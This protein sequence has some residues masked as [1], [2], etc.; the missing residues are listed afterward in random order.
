[1]AAHP[2]PL[3]GVAAGDPDRG[4]LQRQ[5]LGGGRRLVAAGLVRA[6][7]G[8]VSVRLGVGLLITATGARLGALTDSDVVAVPRLG[9]L[10]ARASSEVATHT[11]IL[12]ARPDVGAV[13]HTHSPYAT[14]W[15]CLGEPLE[16]ALEEAGYYRMGSIV[17]L[18]GHAPGGSPALASGAAA[19]LGDGAAVLLERHGAIAVGRDLDVAIDIAESLEHQAQVAWLL[20]GGVALR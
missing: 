1:M 15:S 6:R 12:A 14:A 5:L 9:E 8:N 13:V 18:A 20:R 16:L 4:D 2:A 17:P 19:A 11:A 10:P 7:S 3:R